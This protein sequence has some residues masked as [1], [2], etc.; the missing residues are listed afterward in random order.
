VV[1]SATAAVAE[2]LIVIGAVVLAVKEALP[3]AKVEDVVPLGHSSE[4]F[5]PENCHV[6]FR[7]LACWAGV[8]LLKFGFVTPLPFTLTDDPPP[9]TVQS[10]AVVPP[11][12]TQVIPLTKFKIVRWVT[13][14]VATWIVA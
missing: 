4:T 8:V 6:Q 5:D 2:P 10:V 1:P 7:K 14:D 11:L 9:V 13:G 3:R 12:S